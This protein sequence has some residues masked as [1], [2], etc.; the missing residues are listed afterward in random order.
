[1]RGV[2]ALLLAVGLAAPAA[3]ALAAGGP[4][5]PLAPVL[6]V[7]EIVVSVSD[8][9]ATTRLYREVAGYELL[10][11]GRAGADLGAAWQLPAGAGGAGAASGPRQALVGN[12]VAKFGYLRLVQFEGLPQVQV[13]SS[14]RPFD[15]GGIFNVNV[16]VRDIDASFAALRAAGFQGYADPSRYEL[17][18][19]PYAGAMLRGHDGVVL[20]LLSRLDRGYEDMPTFKAMSHVLNATQ[21]VAD[22]EASRGFFER[23]LGWHKRWEA[24]PKWQ[25]DGRNNMGLPESLVLSG[26]VRERAASFALCKAC[27]GGT[28]E[29]FAFEGIRGHDYAERAQPPNLGLLMYLITVP[30]VDGYLREV[31]GRG[32]EPLAPARAVDLPPYGPVRTAVIRAPGGAWLMFV[33]VLGH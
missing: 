16:L 27:E 25:P 17:F 7:Q 8:L 10:W 33:Q 15:T 18:G 12:P 31:A 30:D 14:A 5:A 22:F 26:A 32:V 29:I 11:Q 28:I 21:M 3:P 23:Q 20:N 1:M 13:R 9:E 24:A 4:G 2:A 6:G 19:R